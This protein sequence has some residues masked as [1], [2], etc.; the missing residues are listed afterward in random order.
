MPRPSATASS[1]VSELGMGEGQVNAGHDLPARHLGD[2][3]Q[4]R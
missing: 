2:E 4:D 1:A 3:F